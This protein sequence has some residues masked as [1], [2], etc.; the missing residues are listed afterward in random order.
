MK[1]MEADASTIL[2]AA[3]EGGWLSNMP[4]SGEPAWQRA[5]CP[6]SAQDSTVG[7]EAQ[8][9]LCNLLFYL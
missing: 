1:S 4:D 6:L 8:N 3:D 9:Y 2:L 7:K 5:Y